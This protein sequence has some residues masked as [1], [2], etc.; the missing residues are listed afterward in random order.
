MDKS[1]YDKIKIS[2]EKSL[3]TGV[4]SGVA[5]VTTFLWLR[6]ITNHQYKYGNSMID[7]AKL[8]Y[9]QGKFIRFYRGYL[10]AITV[11]SICKTGDLNAYYLVNQYNL[12]NFQKNSI[13]S[14]SSCLTRLMIVPIDT[15]DMF[16]QVEG[17]QGFNLLKNKVKNEGIKVLYHGSSMWLTTNFIGTYVW[18]GVYNYLD[19]KFKTKITNENENTLKTDLKNGIIGIGSSLACDIT[20]NPLR[21]LKTYKQ[22][23]KNTITYLS[24]LKNIINETGIVSLFYRGLGTRIITHGLQSSLFVIV[25][26][27]IEIVIN[28]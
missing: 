22:S 14:F 27:K 6:T 12:S 5:N 19:L 9:K 18:F 28:K 13:I 16:L 24:S 17:K 3:K 20:T 8:L 4:G 7:T 21:M 11:A 10:P 15:L 26:K 23:N 25:W 1:F 2:T